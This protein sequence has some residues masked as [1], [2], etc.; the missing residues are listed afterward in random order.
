MKKHLLMK[1]LL[2][3]LVCLVGGT[4]SV[5]GAPT[6]YLTTW[7]GSVGTDNSADLYYG[8]KKVRIAAGETYV[9]TLKNLNDGGADTW[10]NWVVEGNSGGKFFDCCPNGDSWPYGTDAPTPSYT[11]VMATTDVAYFMTKYNGATVTVTISRNAAGDQITV[12]HTSDVLGTTDGNTDKYYGGT[13][14]MAVG[15]AEEWDVYITQ[16]YSHFEVTNVVY[17]ESDGTTTHTHTSAIEALPFN[18]TW[19]DKSATYPFVGGDIVKGTNVNAFRV[20]NTTAT[21]SFDTDPTTNGNQ[22]YTLASDETVTLSFTAYFGWVSGSTTSTVE[23]LN[24]EGVALAS[25]TYTQGSSN[26]TDVSFG[27]TT[28]AGFAAFPGRS[29]HTAGADKDGNGFAS[30]SYA[31][32]NNAGYN[33]V[34]TMTVSDN[35]YVSLRYFTA[36]GHNAVD[37]NFNATLTTSGVGAVKMDIASIRIVDG[38]SNND[39]AIGINN[40]SITSATAPKADVTFTYEDTN[41]NSLA[42]IKSNYVL[43]NVAVG[44]NIADIIPDALKETFYNGDASYKYVYS[45]FT[46]ADSE[47]QAGGSTVTLKF[48]AR[49]KFNFTANAKDADESNLGTIVSGFGYANESTTFY[50]PACVLVDG[51]LYFTADA[52]YSK[53]EIVSSNN[54][55]FPYAYTTSTVNNVKYFFEGENLNVHGTY[56]N[57]STGTKSSESKG[58]SRRPLANSYLY[59]PALAGGNYTVYIRVFGNNAKSENLAIYYCDADGENPVSLDVNTASSTAGNYTTVSNANIAIPDGKCLAFYRGANNSNFV[60]DYIYLIATESVTV[61]SAGYATY[62]S[63]NNLDFTSTGI[64][65]YTAKVNGASKSVVMTQINKVPS[66]TPVILYKEDGATENVPVATT[67]DTPADNDLIAGTGAAVA[68]DGGAGKINYILNNVSGIGFYKAAGQTVA[69]NRAYLQTTVDAA[70]AR[71]TMIFEDDDVTG[72]NEVR[73]QKEDVRSEWFDLQ[74]RKVAQP[75]KGLYIVNGKKVVL[76]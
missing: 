10:H 70:A 66:G 58:D 43:E 34:I 11:P 51:V 61:T 4:S 36:N 57:S 13:Y 25:F 6:S 75:Q 29:S 55:V 9:F 73:S 48:E 24:S 15:A 12:V 63:A 28:V 35:G 47:V 21:A 60:I 7:T 31:F 74:G 46:S 76:K 1:T 23:L 2:V 37:K 49:E 44:A 62:V 53:A 8:T 72:V 64:K 19:I 38:N 68:T 67:T 39:R 5:W 18:R 20:S 30:N 33:P 50:I 42:S 65:A 52:S 40:L 69:A 3:A 26:V 27:G 22:P 71:M 41:G 17:T 32:V 14:T 16:R 59:T 54:Q 56:G 45:T